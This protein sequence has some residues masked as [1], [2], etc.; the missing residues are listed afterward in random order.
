[1]RLPTNSCGEPIKEMSDSYAEGLAEYWRRVAALFEKMQDA[2]DPLAAAAAEPNVQ[3]AD[4]AR[5][6]SSIL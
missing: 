3:I 4:R 5:R 2:A 1:M 6:L